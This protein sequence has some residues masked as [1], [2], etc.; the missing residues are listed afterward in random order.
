MPSFLGFYRRSASNKEEKIVRAINSVLNQSHQDWELIVVADG[1]EKTVEIV[2]QYSDYRIK[3]YH[4][5][6]QS[7]FSGTPRNTGIYHATGDIICYLDID[8]MFGK[9][10]LK[11]INDNFGDNDWVWFNDM[12]FNTNIQKKGFIE[13]PNEEDF[14]EHEVDVNIKGRCGTSNVAHKKSIAWWTPKGTYLHDYHF[15][16]ALRSNKNYTKIQTPFYGIC[17]VPRLL[18]I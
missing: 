11:I 7:M 12:S 9:D 6:K 3:G 15:I 17:H 1:C 14:D 5:Y 4:I 18:D 16:I 13:H 8:D 2:S 10:H